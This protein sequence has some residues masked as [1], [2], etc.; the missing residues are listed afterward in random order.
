MENLALTL[1]FSAFS[2]GSVRIRDMISGRIQLPYIIGRY[3]KGDGRRY[4][5]LRTF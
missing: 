5:T 2:I 4:H 3:G 1:G